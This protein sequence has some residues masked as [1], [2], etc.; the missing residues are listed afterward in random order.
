MMP[1]KDCICPLCGY[2]IEKWVT[3]NEYGDCPNCG[4]T[5]EHNWGTLKVKS[6]IFE[7]SR[8]DTAGNPKPLKSFKANVNALHELGLLSDDNKY[9]VIDNDKRTELRAKYDREGPTQAL[10]K[11][12][13]RE[14][15]LAGSK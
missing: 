8:I 13:A 11:E 3:G 7:N 2:Q 14:R 10:E 12:I 6:T 9:A 1:I 15:L 4:E 5:L